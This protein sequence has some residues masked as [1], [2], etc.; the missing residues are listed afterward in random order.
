MSSCT[1]S[2]LQLVYQLMIRAWARTYVATCTSRWQVLIKTSASLQH[3]THRRRSTNA[4][5]VDQAGRQ[6]TW[7]LSPLL[8]RL[9]LMTVPLLLRCPSK[10]ARGSQ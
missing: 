7:Q 2:Q 9:C 1:A 4:D 10:C 3:E 8:R 6:P 5:M